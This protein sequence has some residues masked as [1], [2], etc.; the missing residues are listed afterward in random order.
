M[1]QGLIAD[2]CQSGDGAAGGL[3]LGLRALPEHAWN[4]VHTW[5][6]NWSDSKNTSAAPAR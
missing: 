5:L 6:L 2:T 3:G 4:W 1:K